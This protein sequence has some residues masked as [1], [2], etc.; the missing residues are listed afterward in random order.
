MESVDLKKRMNVGPDG[1][2]IWSV[3]TEYRESDSWTD[4]VGTIAQEWDLSPFHVQKC[5]R[6]R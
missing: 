3:D 4:P 6:E 2:T 5:E 1:Q